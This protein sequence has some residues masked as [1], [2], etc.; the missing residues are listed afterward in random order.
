MSFD[1]E[2]YP[3]MYIFNTCRAFLRTVPALLFSG[4]EVEDLDTHQ[5]DHVADE[6]RYFCMS[7]PIAPKRQR[8]SA[9]LVD[10]PLDLRKKSWQAGY[11]NKLM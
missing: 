10:D 9:E 8:A 1:E 6:C 11:R 5:E 7:R 2:G 4:S 3:Q